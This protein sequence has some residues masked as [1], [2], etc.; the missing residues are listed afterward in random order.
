MEVFVLRVA[1]DLSLNPPGREVAG[2]QLE[3]THAA[4]RLWLVPSFYDKSIQFQ[5][6][7]VK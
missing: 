4:R 1:T 6:S 3:T 7:I 2:V 5:L